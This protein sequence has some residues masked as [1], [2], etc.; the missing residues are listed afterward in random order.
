MSFFDI[1]DKLDQLFYRLFNITSQTAFFFSFKLRKKLKRNYQYKDLHKGKRCFILGAGP[2]LKDLTIE[3]GCQ[4]NK[5]ITFGVNFLYKSDI[6]DNISPTYYA[7]FDNFFFDRDRF[8]FKAIEKKFPNTIFLTKPAGIKIIEEEGIENNSIMVYSKRYPIKRLNYDLT[9]NMHITFNVVSECIKS[10]LYMGFSEI[11]LLGADYNAFA[12]PMEV[13]CY[14]EDKNK[15]L[16][17]NRLGLLLKNYALTTEFHY[18]LS[19]EAHKKGIKI[20][21]ISSFSLLDAYE[22]ENI[23]NILK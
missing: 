14:E 6:L 20:I 22:K 3:Q 1:K 4:L 23:A 12:Y 16:I 9:Q 7:L 21:N 11:Y 10:A 15:P 19:K 8:A 18:L 17:N 13:H 2:S 5:E